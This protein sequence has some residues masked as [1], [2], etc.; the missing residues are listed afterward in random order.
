M[1]VPMMT[2]DEILTPE[3][4]DAAIR[5]YK[6]TP[7]PRFAR[8]CADAIIGPVLPRINKKTGQE[9]DARYLAYCVEYVVGKIIEEKG[10]G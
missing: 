5:L 10:D 6:A 3:E 8:A 1:A 9:N 7:P 2:L 4:I